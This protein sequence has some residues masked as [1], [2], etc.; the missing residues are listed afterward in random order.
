MAP[1]LLESR[2]LGMEI[3]NVDQITFMKLCVG[4]INDLS[5]MWCVNQT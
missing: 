5:E 1:Y 4:S 3:W 2:E